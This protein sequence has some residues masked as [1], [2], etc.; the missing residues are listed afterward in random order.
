ML[1][2]CSVP[3]KSL[4]YLSDKRTLFVGYLR[5]VLAQAHAASTLVLS[6]DRSL[7]LLGDAGEIVTE[8]RCFLLPA[9]VE[10]SMDTHDSRVLVCFLDALGVDLAILSARMK[11]EVSMRGLSCYCDLDEA[12]ELAAQAEQWLERRPQAEALL[13]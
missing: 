12:D 1:D 11:R 8:S 2:T 4:A 3:V 9:G 7:S 10:I 6:L 13:G 5:P